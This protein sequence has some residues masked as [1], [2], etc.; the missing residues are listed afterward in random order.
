MSSTTHRL[1]IFAILLQHAR[2]HM[3]QWN[4]NSNESKCKWPKLG[5]SKDFR[6]LERKVMDFL[7]ARSNECFSRK[8]IEE[9]A[10]G[11]ISM[12]ERWRENVKYIFNKK[13]Q[14]TIK[15]FFKAL[16]EASEAGADEVHTQGD[17][18]ESRI[19]LQRQ[20]IHTMIAQK[21]HLLQDELL[22]I[23]LSG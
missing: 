3:P 1:R 16:D 14:A 11:T 2:S 20:E 19:N 4:S 9:I 5:F 13:N 8:N 10:I 7:C 15:F 6:D 12:W 22:R 17:V 23:H 18:C 21:M